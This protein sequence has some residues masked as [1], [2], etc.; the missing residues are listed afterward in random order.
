MI[1]LTYADYDARRARALPPQG[2]PRRPGEP[3]DRRGLGPASTPSSRPTVSRRDPARRPPR[4]ATGPFDVLVVGQRGGRAVGRRPAG[5]PRSQALDRRPDQGR[6]LRVGH[7]VGPGRRGGGPAAGDEDSTDLH[8]ADTLA[9]GAGLCD[10]DAVRVL[11]DEGPARVAGADRPRAR[12]STARRP[13]TSAL[14]PGGRPLPAPGS[15]TP[16]ARRPAPRSSGPW[17]TPTRRRPRRCSS[18]G[19][20]STSSSRTAAAAGS[21]ALPPDGRPVEVRADHVVLATGGAGQLFAVTTNPPR[22][23]RRR[24]G[25][26]PA[27]RGAG[28]RRRVRAVPPDR[29]APPGDAAAPALRGAPRPRGPA[30]RRRGRALRRRAGPARRGQPRDGRRGW[31]SRASTHLWLDATGLER[32]DAAL[33][34]HRRRRSPPSGS[35]RRPT[36]CRSPRPPT[37]SRGGVLTDLEGRHRAARPVGGR[38]G[39]LHRRARREP[40]GLELAARG[41]GLRRPGWPRRIAAGRDG[42]EPTGAMRARPRAATRD[43]IGGRVAVDAASRRVRRVRAGRRSVRPTWPSS[44]TAAAGDDRA[45]PASCAARDSL[46]AGG[47]GRCA[48][49]AGGAGRPQ[50]RRARPASSPT[51]SP[52][53]ATLLLG[54]RPRSESRGAHARSDFPRAPTCARGAAARPRRRRPRPASAGAA[55]V[56]RLTATPSIRPVPAVARRGRRALAEDLLPPGDLTAASLPDGRPRRARASWPA[57]RASSP[58]RRC[59]VETPSRQ[60]DPALAVALATATTA[61]AVAPGRRGGH[62]RPGRCGSI[63]TAERTAL[64]F[65]GHLSGV[66]T[67]DPALRRRGARRRPRA[68]RVLDTRKT[69]PGLRALEKAAVRAGRRPQPPGQPLRRRA[70]EGQPPRRLSITEAVAAAPGRCGPARMVEVE[71]D[72]LDQV[73]EALAGRSATR[74][75]STTWPPPSDG[76]RAS[77]SAPSGRADARS[78]SPAASPWRPPPRYAAAGVDRHLGRRPHPLGA[79]LDLGLDLRPSGMTAR[80]LTVLLAIDVGNTETVIGPL[81]ADDGRGASAARR[82]TSASASAPRSEPTAAGLTH[83]WRLSTVPDAHARRARRPAHPAPRPRGPRHRDHRHRASPISSSVPRGDRRAPPDGDRGGSPRCPASSS[84]PG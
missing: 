11:V 58:A 57:S 28:R 16:A 79:V 20:P 5:R 71:C 9:A 42:P 59:A 64:N 13:A 56:R 77:W 34:D 18:A 7:P 69:T 51:S 43:G 22:G 24:A 82:P 65:L 44:A 29:A 31:P 36:G 10:D 48:D 1:V 30:A 84:G 45:A 68:S 23:D 50:R 8:L 78:R 21:T 62:G 17:S 76:L 63:L 67:L 60:V 55:A 3:G 25:D 81:R 41:H 46:G 32:F 66:A 39:R 47:R 12:S 19:S 61:T 4:R 15:S 37:T 72:R 54:A 27:G 52:W 75:C 26:G 70:R 40:A 33:P 2:R 14:R 49:V 38:R 6:A 53:P 80:R 35:T 74:C 83:H 73:D